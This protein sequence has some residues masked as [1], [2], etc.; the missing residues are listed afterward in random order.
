MFFSF[1]FVT[2][3]GQGVNNYRRVCSSDFIASLLVEHSSDLQPEN[4]PTR[5]RCVP[6]P[7]L[8]LVAQLRLAIVSGM[9]IYFNCSSSRG[10]NYKTLALPQNVSSTTAKNMIISPL[11]LKISLALLYEGMTANA[12]E[13]FANALNLRSLL[14]NF[15][16]YYKSLLLRTS[17]VLKSKRKV[18]V[19]KITSPYIFRCKTETTI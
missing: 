2:C 14:S 9:E 11:S 17:Q 18:L 8:P 5:R 12:Q 10:V 6:P 7:N 13:K 19:D 1:L 3:Y 16:S 15:R 4:K